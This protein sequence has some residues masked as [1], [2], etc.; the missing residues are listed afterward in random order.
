MTGYFRKFIVYMDL[1]LLTEK[2]AVITFSIQKS[3][4]DEDHKLSRSNL[5]L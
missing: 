4:K 1:Y 5:N 2:L 3:E